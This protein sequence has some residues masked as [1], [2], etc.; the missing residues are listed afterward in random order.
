LIVGHGYAG[1]S[2]LPLLRQK[3]DETGE[4]GAVGAQGDAVKEGIR[5]EGVMVPEIVA[6]ENFP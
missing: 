4:I 3:V 2:F 1:I 5:I 6:V